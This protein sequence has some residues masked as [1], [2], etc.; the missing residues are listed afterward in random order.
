MSIQPTLSFTSCIAP[1]QDY[2][3]SAVLAYL[4][5]RVDLP[6]AFV[7]EPEWPQ[8]YAALDAGEIHI[9]AICGAPYVRRRDA[10]SPTIELLAAPVFRAPLYDGRPVYFSD[11]IVHAESNFHSF[12]DLRNASFAFNDPGSFSGYEAMRYHLA[13]KNESGSYFGKVIESGAHAHSLQMV[14]DRQVDCAAIDST[15]LEQELADRPEIAAHLRVVELIGPSPMLPWVASTSLDAGIRAQI[16]RELTTMHDSKAGAALL[17]T[18][19]VARF[20]AVT[21]TDYD[22]IR[23]MLK[24]A[25]TIHFDNKIG[26]G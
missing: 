10:P 20:A 21:D 17:Y 25:S 9:A 3:W 18:T 16:R 4:A 12:A 6:F 1:N 19:P 23:E 2:I 5:E 7:T 22:P 13:S 11:V 8:R 24:T 15:M 14:I 26:Q